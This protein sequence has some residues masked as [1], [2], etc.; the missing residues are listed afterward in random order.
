MNGIFCQNVVSEKFITWNRNLCNAFAPRAIAASQLSNSKTLSVSV[1]PNLAI[2]R[3]NLLI[4][5]PMT[6]IAELTIINLNGAVVK[7]ATFKNVTN[8]KSIPVNLIGNAAGN[9][10]LKVTTKLGTQTLKVVVK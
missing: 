3:F 10:L 8:G 1:Y 7:K 6:T 9:Y 5:T 4:K 2:G